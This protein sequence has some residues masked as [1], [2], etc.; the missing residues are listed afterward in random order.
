MS[1]SV[2]GIGSYGGISPYELYAE[3]FS[4][5]MGAEEVQ[6][7]ADAADFADDL[8]SLQGASAVQAVQEREAP[9]PRVEPAEQSAGSG[10][11]GFRR[12]LSY[13]AEDMR[14]IQGSLW[15]FSLRRVTGLSASL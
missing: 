4:G 8:N 9:Y 2:G 13:T 3:R 5:N 10:Q 1:M 11:D 15:G 12:E 14:E 7:L 6:E